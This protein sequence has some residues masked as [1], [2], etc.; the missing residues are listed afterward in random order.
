MTE[1]KINLQ[2]NL[3]ELLL[4]GTING[5]RTKQSWKLA[6]RFELAE[7]YLE[8]YLTDANI[9]RAEALQ[10]QIKNRR[11][12]KRYW[13]NA[14]NLFQIDDFNK[15]IESYLNEQKAIKTQRDDFQNYASRF[16]RIKRE[17]ETWDF[18]LTN[19]EHL[20]E[21]AAIVN[22]LYSHISNYG[23]IKED[24]EKRLLE[25]DSYVLNYANKLDYTYYPSSVGYELRKTLTELYNRQNKILTV[26]ALPVEQ[27][28]VKKSI[29][30]KF[31]NYIFNVFSPK[32]KLV[33]QEA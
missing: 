28:L 4:K 8:Q 9:E 10:K 19:G 11:E 3:E 26:N 13:V 27:R 1:Q 23:L 17:I 29:W 12:D 21:L 22:N 33:H 16:D 20:L 14:K 6:S 15:R 31:K 7:R 24:A 5:K 18:P 32:T 30:N 25:M 2:I